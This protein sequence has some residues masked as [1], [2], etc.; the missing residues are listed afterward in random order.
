MVL[1]DLSPNTVSPQ[2]WIMT[3][4]LS[5][6]ACIL[7]FLILFSYMVLVDLS[8]NTVSPLEWIM[9]GLLSVLAGIHVLLDTTLLYGASGSQS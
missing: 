2:E 4:L 5:V 9:T 3:G 7:C 1:V 6:S 8:P